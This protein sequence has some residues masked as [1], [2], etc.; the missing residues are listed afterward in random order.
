MVFQKILN[1]LEVY[2]YFNREKFVKVK[3]FS[4]ECFAINDSTIYIDIMQSWSHVKVPNDNLTY[5]GLGIFS[6]QLATFSLYVCN[7][8]P[9]HIKRLLLG[10]YLDMRITKKDVSNLNNLQSEI[11]ESPIIIIILI[12][13]SNSSLSVF[14]RSWWNWIMKS[15]LNAWHL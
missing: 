4:C 6:F 5:T 15:S 11:F 12:I 8:R 14:E 7:V 10:K 1:I 2:L 3:R 9:K 13:R